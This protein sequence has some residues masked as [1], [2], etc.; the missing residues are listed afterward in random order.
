MSLLAIIIVTLLAVAGAGSIAAWLMDR[1]FDGGERRRLYLVAPMT[2]NAD[3]A[4][5]TLRTLAVACKERGCRGVHAVCLDCGMD[6]ETRA[7]CE[8]FCRDHGEVVL[9][10][11]ETFG[12]ACTANAKD[13]F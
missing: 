7:I 1:L 6:K 5:Q 9:L 4:E 13:I 3:S 8:R 2:E 12:A 10:T 11:Q